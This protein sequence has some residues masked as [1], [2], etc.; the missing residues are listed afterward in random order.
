M[1]AIITIYYK[2]QK[3]NFKNYFYCFNSNN[4]E[5][6][7][8]KRY[9]KYRILYVSYIF[10]ISFGEKYQK[11]RDI[12]EKNRYKKK[13]YILK[14]TFYLDLTF[15]I[16][17]IQLVRDNRE[18]ALVISCRLLSNAVNYF[19]AWKLRIRYRARSF[20]YYRVRKHV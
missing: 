8:L 20:R 17:S 7:A 16:D 18:L 2:L 19:R 4:L 1:F 9:F 11:S 13:K 10:S 15:S 3:L 12:S 5:Q 14:S 6:K